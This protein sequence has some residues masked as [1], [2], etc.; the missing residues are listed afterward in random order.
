[1]TEL[2]E[3]RTLAQ[4]KERMRPRSPGVGGALV[5]MAVFVVIFI[6]LAVWVGAGGF[7]MGD[8]RPADHEA[9]H[10]VVER[11][12]DRWPQVPGP[13]ERY[14]SESWAAQVGGKPTEAARRL[15]MAVAL[16]P[17]QD[18]ALLRL[19]ILDARGAGAGLLL[20]GE[21]AAILSAFDEV[22][23][24]A[25]L[26]PAAKAW[27]ALSEG[28]V[29]GAL[30]ALG[31]DV[32]DPEA[33]WAVLRADPGAES[34]PTA[35]GVLLAAWP[36][37][38]EA[39]AAG[40]RVAWRDGDLFGVEEVANACLSAGAGD[41][42]ALR[43]LADVADRLGD[44]AEARR[45]YREAGLHL[46]AAAVASQSG[47]PLEPDEQDALLE[48]HAVAATHRLW[49][50]VGVGDAAAVRAAV[51][52]LAAEGDG[53][54]PP[55]RV[56]LAAG[57]AW[58]G[59]PAAAEAGLQGQDG[60]WAAIVRE[61][62][63]AG[64]GDAAA[65]RRGQAAWP[66]HPATSGP[67]TDPVAA[68]LATGPGDRLVP[69]AWV[70]RAP[71]EPGV[72]LG[73]ARLVPGPSPAGAAADALLAQVLAAPTAPVG[74]QLATLG[75]GDGEP[76]L[77]LLATRAAVALAPGAPPG[78]ASEALQALRGRHPDAVAT[79]LLTARASWLLDGDAAAADRALRELAADRP[80]LVG[81]LVERYRVRAA[82]RP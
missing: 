52:A 72:A 2:D 80:E 48:P 14:L 75:D 60:V 17:G 42:G 44:A 38:P 76:S 33:A 56:A 68:W 49:H 46:H 51:D 34:V 28:D 1:M 20:P 50:G 78:A 77:A 55:M 57:R 30:A 36:G 29:D 26:L 5:V 70:R 19:V 8:A 15:G 16:D 43:G 12:A 25:P 73:P 6:G 4:A 23:P 18:E 37:H 63:T 58:L 40:V 13:P 62:V 39:C 61:A 32:A 82:V 31:A 10:A 79:R 45:R 81:V 41:T 35:P 9:V 67:V 74:G 53:L 64:E 65:A 11:L 27:V 54:V 69:L 59:D 22:A 47:R 3:G 24:D 71:R 7:V 66:D 21:R